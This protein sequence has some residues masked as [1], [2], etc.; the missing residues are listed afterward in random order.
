MSNRA[1]TR[2]IRVIA[3][4]VD[5]KQLTLYQENGETIAI[6]QGDPRLATIVR[7]I[8]PVLAVGGGSVAIVDI[9]GAPSNNPYRDYEEQGTGI[10]FFKVA[11]ATLS[12]LFSRAA[13]AI[14]GQPAEPERV[15]PQSIGAVPLPVPVSDKT[16]QLLSAADE[17]IANAIPASAPEFNDDD[18]GD[19]GN[20]TIVAVVGNEVV[21][22]IEKIRPQ[23]KHAADEKSPNGMANF[24]RRVASVAAKRRHSAED[25]LRF[26]E[27]GDL[28]IADDGSIVIYKVLAR[29]GEGYVDCHTKKVAQKVGSYVCMDE[30][31]VDHD[32]SNECSNGLHVARRGYIRNFGGDV[33]VLAKVAPEDVIAV[34]NYDAN[35]MRVCG[36]HIL[37]EL[38]EKAFANLRQNKPFTDNEDAKLLL[39]RALAGDHEAPIEE[40]RL[41]K[42]YGEGLVITDLRKPKEQVKEAK[43]LTHVKPATAIITDPVA[44]P[45]AP[46]VNPKEVVA[47]VQRVRAKA[48]PQK[49]AQTKKAQR[50][51]AKGHTEGR[52]EKAARLHD[53]MMKA[54]SADKKKEMAHALM[55]HK[56]KV[57][58]GWEVLGL[59]KDTGSKIQGILNKG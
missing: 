59:P 28:P 21:G 42:Q 38:S 22:S 24:M 46:S 20:D 37:F 33:C 3:A 53:G 32:R 47:Q 13:E 8:T 39:G 44:E 30:S 43:V 55:A 48:K 51:Q 14:S 1:P 7:E 34:P 5:T 35:K 12:R 36:Y 26:L 52:Q 49:K 10:R 31:L 6:P 50:P 56:K 4:I 54:T 15:L 29:K 11:K 9:G 2:L 16:Q 17:I 57:K 19:N 41:T 23:L 58:L 40:V 45:A 25:L 27:R 18:T